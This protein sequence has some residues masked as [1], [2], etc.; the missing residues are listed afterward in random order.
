MC[1]LTPAVLSL[2]RTVERVE[3]GAEHAVEFRR[4]D[5]VA[6][7]QYGQ[8]R[9]ARR[10]IAERLGP[11]DAALLAGYAAMQ[12]LTIDRI[13]VGHSAARIQSAALT[14]EQNA[15]GRAGAGSRD[16]ARLPAAP[17]RGGRHG[18][19]RQRSAPAPV[20]RPVLKGSRVQ[21]IAL[22]ARSVANIV[23]VY[24][25]RASLDPAEFSGHSLPSGY[26]TSAAEAGAEVEAN[27]LLE[28]RCYSALRAS[29]HRK[30]DHAQ[31]HPNNDQS[32][33]YGPRIEGDFEKGEADGARG[34]LDVIAATAR[35][36][37]M[38][39]IVRSQSFP[40]PRP[41]VHGP[42]SPAGFGI[43]RVLGSAGSSWHTANRRGGRSPCTTE[44]RRSKG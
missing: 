42:P 28:D 14:V 6:R 25:E 26:L 39:W 33:V 5:H 43:S 22:T 21:S 31:H 23:K 16:P 2:P 20:F 41:D 29:Q 30:P 40:G 7:L 19:Q 8:Q 34:S 11:R 44:S 13:F 18:W 36:W 35:A 24:A 12:G 38:L 32:D 37:G 4:D 10:T 9:R 3:V 15:P 17:G 1:R 27:V